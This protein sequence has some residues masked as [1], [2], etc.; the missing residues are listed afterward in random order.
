MACLDTTV[1]IDLL[2]S[3]PEW[4]S[5][6]LEKIKEM[7][8]RGEAN[9]TTRLNLAEVYVG[10]E[11]SL[12]R[13]RDEACLRGVLDH[14]DAVLEFADSAAQVY[15]ETTAHLRRIGRPAGNM[16]VLIAATAIA[17]GHSLVTRNPS[18]FADMPH[19]RVETY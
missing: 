18:H 12:D 8:S 7:A 10:I 3:N 5:R 17:A 14:L 16:D 9:V 19:L 13:E 1:L 11:L 6:A 15:G 2:R 4:R